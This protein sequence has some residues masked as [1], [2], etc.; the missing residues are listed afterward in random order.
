MRS[1]L[2]TSRLGSRRASWVTTTSSTDCG[3]HVGRSRHFGKPAQDRA[4]QARTRR[5]QHKRRY[6]IAAQRF[7]AIP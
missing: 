1:Q 7:S 2:L 4:A 5:Q 6:D 3:C